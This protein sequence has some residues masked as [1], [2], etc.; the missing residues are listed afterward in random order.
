MFKL[1][2][3]VILL[4]A[5]TPSA[6]SNSQK[7]NQDSALNATQS[8]PQSAAASHADDVQSVPIN[9]QCVQVFTGKGDVTAT[10]CFTRQGTLPADTM[11][12]GQ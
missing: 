6:T 7:A 3:V 10:P 8:N 4:T 2:V 11:L 5:C 1:L 12:Q 9:V